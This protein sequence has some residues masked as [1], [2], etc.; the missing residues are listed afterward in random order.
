MHFALPP[1][2]SSNPPPYARRSRPSP[3]LRRRGLQLVAICLCGALF[4]LF[5]FSKLFSSADGVPPGTPTVVIV[6]P[7]DRKVFSSTYIDKVISNREIYAARHGED[8][9]CM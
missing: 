1:R 3:L 5:V 4:V 8:A 2:K 6:T 7:L 9:L